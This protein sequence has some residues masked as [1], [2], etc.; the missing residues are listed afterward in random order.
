M[1][2]AE[3][4]LPNSGLLTSERQVAIVHQLH[5]LAEARVAALAQ[6]DVDLKEGLLHADEEIQRSR[7][8]LPATFEQHLQAERQVYEAQRKVIF[9]RF[10]R[11]YGTL[12][13]EYERLS[14]EANSAAEHLLR[15][16]QRRLEESRWNSEAVYEAVKN[17][18]ARK[19]EEFKRQA[20]AWIERLRA[21]WQQV[22]LLLNHWKLD[23]LAQV[24]V[25]ASSASDNQ[26]SASDRLQKFLS[27]LTTGRQQMAALKLP[28]I[29]V[30]VLPVLGTIALTALL[31]LLVGLLT[32]NA[33]ALG[34]AV[35]VSIAIGVIGVIALRRRARAVVAES[36]LP[37][38]QSIADA[39]AFLPRCVADQKLA[40]EQKQQENIAHRDN[41]IRDAENHAAAVVSD[42][43][44]RRDTLRDEYERVYPPQLQKF[45]A[46]RD[47]AMRKLDECA[48]WS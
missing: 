48:S 33:I 39:E 31:C 37:L 38:A 9:E 16:E 22:L 35:V 14:A 10:D 24:S 32:K 21:E 11:E 7:R 25:A 41:S 17:E 26:L 12:Q 29:S 4:T 5:A 40:C 28:A 46:D 18:P 44:R 15:T 30:S 36:F 20:D 6:I 2:V 45:I 42:S 47:D 19:F 8:D 3:S 13:I 43:Q 34:V 1:N 23:D 27:D